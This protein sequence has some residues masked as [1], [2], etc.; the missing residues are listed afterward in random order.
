MER[1]IKGDLEMVKSELIKN[2]DISVVRKINEQKAKKIRAFPFKETI[3][4]IYIY[5]R[6]NKKTM[7]DE[8]EFLLRKKVE[9]VNITE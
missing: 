6:E 5:A 8:F 7:V 1:F 4:E 9:V 3:S 2:I